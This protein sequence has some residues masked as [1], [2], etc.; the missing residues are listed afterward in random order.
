MKIS[1]CKNYYFIANDIGEIF[2]C[3]SRKNL[4]IIGKFKGITTS[5]TD[6]QVSKDLLLCSSLDSFVRMY[7]IQSKQLIEKYYMNKPIYSLYVKFIE[8]VDVEIKEQEINLQ[9]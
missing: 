2:Q 9:E 6:L 7:D 8:T 4:Q 1:L 5:I 3:D